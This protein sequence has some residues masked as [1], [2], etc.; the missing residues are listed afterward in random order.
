MKA[1]ESLDNR[2]VIGITDRKY[3]TGYQDKEPMIQIK[4]AIL[5]YIKHMPRNWEK[6]VGTVTSY[7][8]DSP[9]FESRHG[10]Q[11][12]SIPEPFNPALGP[13]QTLI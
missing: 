3:V 10:Q 13:T 12:S 9:G 2:Y 8:S 1:V 7:G 6:V 4:W 11:F 5:I